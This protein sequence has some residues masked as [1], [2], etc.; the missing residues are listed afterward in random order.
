MT[1]RWNIAL[2]SMA[3]AAVA[4]VAVVA[5]A[6]GAADD[7]SATVPPDSVP[8]GSG[9]DDGTGA[10]RTVSVTGH[11]TVQ[12]VPDVANLSAGVQVTA[13]TA[14]EAM[15]TVGTKSQALVDTLKGLGIAAEDIQT[16]GLSLY[17]SFT[18]DGSTINGYQASTSVS[19]TVHE[20]A[21]IGEVLD[22]LKGLVGEELTL[23]GISFSYDD[24]EAVLAEARTAAIEN[25]KVRAGQY[26]DAAGA[27]LGEILRIVESSVATPVF[28]REMMTAQDSAAA[29]P[30]AIEPGSQDLA[31]DVS[32]VFEL[33]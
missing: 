13:D 7:A 16:S 22:G 26:A 12:V 21:R 25:A 4:A 20:V 10:D 30:L 19:V 31:A 32:V 27:E 1:T 18:N 14:A 24:P 5:L 8:T 23:G 28:A 17:P 3:G 29:A 9:S 15:D 6:G 33:E 11:G 2:A